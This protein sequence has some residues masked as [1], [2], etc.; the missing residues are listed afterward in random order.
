[1]R[2]SIED[3]DNKSSSTE[4]CLGFIGTYLDKVKSEDKNKEEYCIQQAERTLNEKL[5]PHIGTDKATNRTKAFFIGYMVNKLLYAY[6]G[7]T[8]E[9][10]RDHYGKK[11]LDLTGSLL[12][13]QFKELFKNSFIESAK[14]NLRKFFSSNS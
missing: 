5:L 6:L 3:V 12:I 4:K 14:I 11:R 8:D 9:D 13:S 1:M 2:Y 10:D 7:K